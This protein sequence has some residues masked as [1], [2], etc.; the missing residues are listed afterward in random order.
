MFR[1][2]IKKSSAFKMNKTNMVDPCLNNNCS[3][4]EVNHW[5][6]DDFILEKLIPIVGVRPFPLCEL[7][8]LV[9]SVA[10]LKPTQIF[11]WGTN[12]GKSARIF[13]ET[14]E[15]F[16]ICSDIHS[17]DLPDD[18]SHNE[19]PQKQ[20]GKLVWDIKTVN[21]HQGDG[22]NISLDIYKN[23]PTKRPL[24][25]LDG[26]HSYESVLRELN[27]IINNIS[28]PI[29]L[30]HDTFYQSSESNYNIGPYKACM[31]IVD[32]YPKMF[33]VRST[34]NGLPGL[35]LLF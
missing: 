8:L 25:F 35:T 33:N 6:I 9:S 18:V 3:E 20:R 14:C 29:I 30:I 15:Q 5:I 10:G 16:K 23:N 12:I 24:F 1:K 2:N 34:M 21:L 27:Q 28:S 26:D 4:F 19:H 11:E 22:V 31:E 32:K 7:S 13:Y 17:I